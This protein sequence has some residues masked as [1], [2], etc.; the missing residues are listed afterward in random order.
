[1]ITKFD[2]DMLP[3]ARGEEGPGMVGRVSGW[4]DDKLVLSC[5]QKRVALGK[6][7]DD[8][9]AHFR[10]NPCFLC[11]IT[12]LKMGAAFLYFSGGELSRFSFIKNSE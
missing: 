1:M 10:A 3:P 12:V 5:V 8:M 9:Y 7:F 6:Y 11:C 4:Y 2:R